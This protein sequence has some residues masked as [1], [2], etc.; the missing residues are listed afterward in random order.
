MVTADRAVTMTDAPRLILDGYG[1]SYRGGV[2]ALDGVSLAVGGGECLAVLGESGSG[3]STLCRALLGL[4]D[5]AEE[6]GSLRI[7]GC[8]R[9]G[10]SEREWQAMRWT[11]VALAFQATSALDPLMPIGRQV[12]EPITTHL[13]VSRKTAAEQAAGLFADVGLDPELADRFPRELSGGQRRLALVAMALACD[14]GILVLDEPSAG[15][16]PVARLKL[17][18]AL[19]SVRASRDVAMLLV[20]HDVGLAAALADDVAMLYRGWIAERGPAAIVLDDPES[21]YAFGL[22]N[23]VPRLHTVKEL[24]GLPPDPTRRVG[25]RV[26]AAAAVGCPFADRCAQVIDVCR[27]TSPPVVPVG[28]G[29]PRTVACHR[30]GLARVLEATE[31]VKHYR[32]SAGSASVVRAVDGIDLHVRAGEVL[33]IAGLNA[34]G[35][36]TLVG[37]LSGQIDADGGSIRIDG[38]DLSGLSRRELRKARRSIQL[39]QQ[40]PFLAVSPRLTV[41]EIVAEP[42]VIERPDV[43]VECWNDEVCVALESVRLPSDPEFLAKHAAEVSGGELQRISIARALIAQPRILL[44]DEPVAMLDPSEQAEV[45]QLVKAAQVRSGLS[46]VIVSHDLAVLLRIADRL[47][48]LDR[49]R[50]AET[51]RGADLYRAP[52]TDALRQLL[53]A[54]GARHLEPPLPST[55]NTLRRTP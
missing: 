12:A 43:A 21:P 10:Q 16:D 20:T 22:L 40:D 4:N 2:R 19:Q 36:S 37:L 51:G 55:S 8:E 47:V 49:G 52:R 23:A 34:A 13:G 48:V 11:Q 5:G 41:A 32:R 50:V 46:V 24:R 31:V 17:L 35:K 29:V 44:L 14:P 28:D 25:G 45:I 39:V 27:T 18:A 54:A 3:K 6:S 1:V 30:G 7:G 9:A 38:A 42:L 15:L 33:G 53:V 26:S